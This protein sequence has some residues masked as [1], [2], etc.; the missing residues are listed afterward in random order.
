MIHIGRT[1]RVQMK[2]NCSCEYVSRCH[3]LTP[4]SLL[5]IQPTSHSIREN[6]FNRS[7]N[8]DALHTRTSIHKSIPVP[9]PQ[10]S[11][12]NLN[13]CTLGCY[14]RE[15]KCTKLHRY[16]FLTNYSITIRLY[17]STDIL[18]FTNLPYY[19]HI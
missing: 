10:P 12:T 2:C 4:Y 19:Q 3:S 14:F 17:F 6:S 11:T 9:Q 13:G 18:I 7:M 1:C 8:S 16:A 15:A 5:D